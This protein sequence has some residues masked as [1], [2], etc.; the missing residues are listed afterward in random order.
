MGRILNDSRDGLKI[1]TTIDSRMQG[2][3]E[4]AVKEHLGGELQTQFFKHWK[5]VKNAPFSDMDS[6]T[7]WILSG[8]SRS[9]S[10][11]EKIVVSI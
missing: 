7:M 6:I 1:Y 4:E 8:I 3:A 9:I 11:W 10:F 2:Y 5:G